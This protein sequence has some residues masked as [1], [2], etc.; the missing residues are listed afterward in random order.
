[1]IF[2]YIYFIPQFFETPDDG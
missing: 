1:V 2:C